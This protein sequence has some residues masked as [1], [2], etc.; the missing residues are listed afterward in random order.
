MY[1]IPDDVCL[2]L[3]PPCVWRNPGQ[4]CS[5]KVRVSC[6]NSGQDLVDPSG[7]GEVNFPPDP[8]LPKDSDASV[9]NRSE[10]AAR[11][12]RRNSE[13]GVIYWVSPKKGKE[14]LHSHEML[15]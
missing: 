2:F 12:K 10:T 1:G 3:V 9:Q 13:K 8:F 4:S 15:N 11:G 6:L 7:K 14:D 5:L